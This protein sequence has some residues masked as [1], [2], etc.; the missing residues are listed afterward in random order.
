MYFTEYSLDTY[1]I[2]AA[3]FQAFL[4]REQEETVVPLDMPGLSRFMKDFVMADNVRS[5]LDPPFFSIRE[6]VC[7]FTLQ[8]TVFFNLLFS[9]WQR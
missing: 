3:E 7:L 8:I 5:Q 6:V 9:F 4:A 2:D 1:S